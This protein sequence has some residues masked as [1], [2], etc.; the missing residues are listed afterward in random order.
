MILA[1][2]PVEEIVV[3][4]NPRNSGSSLKR[5]YGVSVPPFFFDRKW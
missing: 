2:A 5:E 4:D 1:L 3:N